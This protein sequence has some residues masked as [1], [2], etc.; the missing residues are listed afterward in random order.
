MFQTIIRATGIGIA[1]TVSQVLSIVTPFIVYSSSTHRILPT[2]ILGALSLSGGLL[3]IF[4]P[5]TINWKL[6][7]T[8]QDL[9]NRTLFGIRHFLANITCK[10][11]RR[12]PKRSV[13]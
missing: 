1:T 7:D 8:V 9:G 3:T 13:L 5:E 2:L 10:N 4:L 12:Q 6:P 11:N